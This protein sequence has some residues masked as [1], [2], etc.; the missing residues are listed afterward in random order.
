MNNVETIHQLRIQLWNISYS[1]YINQS[2][3]SYQWWGIVALL[4]IV[5]T[6]WWKLVDKTRLIEILLFGSFVTVMS[7]LFDLWGIS[8]AR[9]QYNIGLLPFQLAPFPFDY[10][11]I[12]ILL[13]LSY[14]YSSSWLTYIINSSL[15][16]AFISFIIGPSFLY[17]GIMSYFDWNFIYFFLGDIAMAA[18]ARV[19]ILHILQ[20]VRASRTENAAVSRYDSIAQ[21]ATKP[22][23]NNDNNDHDH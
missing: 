17:F 6:I 4:I 12:P 11:V 16:S 9:W 3:F 23:P 14:Q 10:S 7:T 21:P 20:T 1:D 19:V 22:L 18:I 15:S 8:A 13:M 5:Y 2:L